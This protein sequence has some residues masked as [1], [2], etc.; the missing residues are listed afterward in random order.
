M[1]YKKAS[2]ALKTVL[3]RMS[4]L[5]VPV[6]Y[7]FAEKMPEK[8]PAAI[9]QLS[10]SPADERLDSASLTVTVRFD[11]TLLFPAEVSAAA[12]DE[13][14]EAV[15]ELLGELRAENNTALLGDSGIGFAVEGVSQR[16]EGSE[17][18]AVVVTVAVRMVEEG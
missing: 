8:F 18:T 2:D 12:H 15:D 17:G 7:G 4:S 11:V 13:W 3:G 10:G 1:G 9:V 5:K 16:P 6:I 14:C